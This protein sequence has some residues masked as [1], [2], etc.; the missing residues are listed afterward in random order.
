MGLVVVEVDFVTFS[1]Q[2]GGHGIEGEIDCSTHV[3]SKD[4]TGISNSEITLSISNHSPL[5]APVSPTC[6][7]ACDMALAGCLHG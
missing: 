3:L 4:I 1:D 6:F 7:P 5:L 2:T